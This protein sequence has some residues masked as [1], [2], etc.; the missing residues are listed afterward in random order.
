M[1]NVV[2]E[3]FNKI[4]GNANIEV[5]CE[6]DYPCV[7]IKVREFDKIK[8][9]RSSLYQIV[10]A[11]FSGITNKLAIKEGIPI[12]IVIRAS[13]GHNIPS[14]AE[15]STSFRINIGLIPKIYA[16]KVLAESLGIFNSKFSEMLNQKLWTDSDSEM[17][18][19]MNKNIISYNENKEG[20]KVEKWNINDTVLELLSKTGDSSGRKVSLQI[21]R[22]T[23]Y[24]DILANYCHEISM[25]N[26][27]L[28]IAPIKKLLTYLDY[29]T[30]EKKTWK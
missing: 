29:Q 9:E 11:Y 26:N 10:M 3:S 17:I 7:I 23:K 2:V 15:T 28:S 4:V 21:T 12:E 5:Y 8:N 30:V 27:E 22:H 6:N 25:D 14:L 18:D 13:F 20:I 19:A 1:C 16:E 24:V